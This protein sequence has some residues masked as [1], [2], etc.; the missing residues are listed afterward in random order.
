[1]RYVRVGLKNNKGYLQPLKL[2]RCFENVSCVSFKNTK[3]GPKRKASLVVKLAT[4]LRGTIE[5]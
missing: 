2:A 4:T 5:N 1:M 3:I